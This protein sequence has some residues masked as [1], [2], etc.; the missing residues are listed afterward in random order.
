MDQSLVQE[1]PFAE[2]MVIK[3]K[4]KKKKVTFKLAKGRSE[5]T[6]F[7]VEGSRGAKREENKHRIL[8]E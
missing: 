1:V 7:Q 4:K 5:D 8:E 2:D 3:L 6:A